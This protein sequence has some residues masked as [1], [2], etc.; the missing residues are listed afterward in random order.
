MGHNGHLPSWPSVALRRSCL[1]EVQ[2]SSKGLHLLINSN[3]IRF[4]LVMRWHQTKRSQSLPKYQEWMPDAGL[5][6]H[7]VYALLATIRTQSVLHLLVSMLGT[8][9]MRLCMPLLC[10]G[11]D[12]SHWFP[13]GFAVAGCICAA[14][15]CE[16]TCIIHV[17]VMY[18]YQLCNVKSVQAY[19]SLSS[20]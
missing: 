20:V 14:P 4:L 2:A 7:V 13:N 1:E 5:H 12:N 15:M 19:R 16:T 6:Q 18:C 3:M 10:L 9:P 8:S 17:Y 11:N